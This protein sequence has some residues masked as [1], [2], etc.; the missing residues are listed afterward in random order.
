M[1]LPAYFNG[2]LVS[3]TML[4]IR[5]QEGYYKGMNHSY[6]QAVVIGWDNLRRKFTKQWKV[7]H[8]AFVNQRKLSNLCLYRKARRQKKRKA[9]KK[10]TGK[11]RKTRR[12]R[13]FMT[14]FLS[15][16]KGGR[17]DA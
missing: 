9:D 14:L 1:Q 17:T 4:R 3:Y 5:G 6:K 11:S 13:T 2:E 16:K 8:K 10:K 7:Q 12:Q 15:Y